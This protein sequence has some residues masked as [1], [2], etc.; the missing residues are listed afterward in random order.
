VGSRLFNFSYFKLALIIWT[1]ALGYSIESKDRSGESMCYNNL[2]SA[3]DS[4][5]DYRKA[6]EYHEKALEIKS[7]ISDRSG[8]ANCYDNLGCPAP[9]YCTTF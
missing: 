4:S 3:Y 5:G 9:S 7:Q 8:E 6:I 1:K 2:G